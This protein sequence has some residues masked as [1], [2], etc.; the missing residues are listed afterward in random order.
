VTPRGGFFLERDLPEVQSNPFVPLRKRAALISLSIGGGM[1]VM[2]M[3]A[4]FLTHSA[5][6]FSDALE[7]IVHVA[8]TSMAMYSV[9]LSARPADKTHPYGHGKIEFF[10]AGFEGAM[11]ILAAIAIV[12]QAVSEI[13]IGHRLERLDVGILFT[14]VA[15][16]VNLALG[17]YLIR[18]GKQTGSIT[19][20]ADGK[21]VLTDSATS[22]G[23]VAGLGLV[24]LTGW[25]ILDPL[26]AIAV[27]L[28][29]LVSGYRLLRL[30]VGGLM[31][32]AHP[33][34]L[35]KILAIA[36]SDRTPAWIDLHHLRAWR[37]GEIYHVDF[38]LTVPFYWSVNEAHAFQKKVL[39][40]IARELSSDSQV[41][42]HLDPCIPAVCCSMCKVS[43]CPERQHEFVSRREWTVATVTGPEA[44][45]QESVEPV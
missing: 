44:Y 17:T 41:L 15:S 16:I 34:T 27:A 19:I 23:V 1:L 2:K 18:I 32:E 22:F 31:D 28:N 40:R 11:I 29:I 20:A 39:E 12:Y 9:L 35:E 30:S 24:L 38:H 26:V 8:A 7:S 37:S 3:S 14:V 13:V 43:P 45:L 21:H 25:E 33:E 36:L 10:S 6:I 42:I 5:A 4:Y